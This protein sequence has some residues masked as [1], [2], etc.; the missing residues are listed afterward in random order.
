MSRLPSLE[1]IRLAHAEL[2]PGV[3]DTPLVRSE[4]LS[5]AL[6]ANVWLKN[7]TVGPV[8]SFKA[9]G[10]LTALLRADGS[11]SPS[12]GACTSSTGNHGQGVA[13]AARQVG[14]PAHIFLP[15]GANPV[16]RQMIAAFGATIHDHGRDI[17]EAKD[18]AQAFALREGLLFVDDGES[19]DLMEGA[20]TVG[21]EI[22]RAL[23][24]IDVV[25][26]P[27]GS[28][29]LAVGVAAAIKGLQPSARVVAVQSKGSPAMVESF[30]AR[31]AVELPVDTVADG[32]AC[33]VP[34]QQAL[35]GLWAFVDDAV[36][37]SDGALL[38]AIRTLLELGRV[39]V[40]PAGAAGLAAA[41]DRRQDL[42]GN[43][44]VLVLTGSNIAPEAL[45]R[46]VEGPPLITS[47]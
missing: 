14:W 26:V 39:L 23:D 35:D 2:P 15:H 37:L 34:A 3:R 27:M 43:R 44:V 6:G 8:A 46:A 21:L 33:R 9:R 16:K 1:G 10:A 13:Y 25:F 4:L 31:R 40:E 17:D 12:A 30:H 32:L 41:W 42:K 11:G 29:T 28:G 24:G 47:S 5:G 19:P 18:E 36:A 7:E 38:S 22:A 20:G 45:R